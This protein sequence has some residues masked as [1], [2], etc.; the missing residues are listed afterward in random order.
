VFGG[1]ASGQAMAAR[2][3]VG[4]LSSLN[5]GVTVA[6]RE[7][8]DPVL[9]RALTDAPNATSMGLLAAEGWTGGARLSFPLT[10]YLTARGGAEGDLTADKL[11]AAR[12]S[13]EFHDRCGCVV[14]G[15]NGAERIGRPGVDVWLSV[16][17][18]R[19]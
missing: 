1:E 15:A 11:L 14:I 12:A 3:R 5:L 10:A 19:H 6:V 2:L 8:I 18:V 7:G 17:I 4:L 13:L 9:A 16:G